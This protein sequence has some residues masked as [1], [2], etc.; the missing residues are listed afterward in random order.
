MEKQLVINI[1]EV[2][3]SAHC[4][5]SEDGQKVYQLIQKALREGKRI[6]LSFKNIE[7]LTSAFLNSAIGQ[8]YNEFSDLDI[9][10]H[11]AIADASQDDLILLKRVVNR[12][13]EFFKNPD[14]FKKTTSDMLGDDDE[15]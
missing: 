10:D 12:A 6:T 2:V 14:R 9:K 3:E 15:R 8:L 1:L 11:I 7:D 4:T 5:S 13:K